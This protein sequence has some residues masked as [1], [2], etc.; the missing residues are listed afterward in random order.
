MSWKGDLLDIPFKQRSAAPSLL[1]EYQAQTVD[2]HQATY[3]A[4]AVVAIRKIA[5]S[6]LVFCIFSF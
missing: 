6:G 1:T 3:N 4:Y 2:K 5:G